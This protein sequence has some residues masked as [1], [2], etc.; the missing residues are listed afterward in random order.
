MEHLNLVATDVI[1]TMEIWSFDE[2]LDDQSMKR[3]GW[4]LLSVKKHL[5]VDWISL[6]TLINA[7]EILL[8]NEVESDDHFQ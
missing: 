6:K 5:K 1:E 2:G 3:S 4:R 8:K 7:A